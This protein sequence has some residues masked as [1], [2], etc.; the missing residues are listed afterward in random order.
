[1]ERIDAVPEAIFIRR[2]SKYDQCI[3]TPEMKDETVMLYGHSERDLAAMYAS[4]K[5]DWQDFLPKYK[6][7]LLL[8]IEACIKDGFKRFILFPG[9]GVNDWLIR[10][11]D[12]GRLFA[13][14]GDIDLIIIRQP[15]YLRWIP[16]DETN[17]LE[18]A[19]CC[20]VVHSASRANVLLAAVPYARKCITILRDPV[21]NIAE[22]FSQSG[23]ECVN[24]DPYALTTPRT[25]G[26]Q[27]L[28][29]GKIVH[30]PFRQ[31]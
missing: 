10:A 12:I 1:M 18:R 19:D 20:Y 11:A 13:P 29:G 7:K 24:I 9:N 27:P 4:Q 5:M 8:L 3:L 2:D 26:I 22:R 31:E 17:L 6:L 25:P 15:Y 14:A 28:Q 23:T 16:R 21:S 30:L